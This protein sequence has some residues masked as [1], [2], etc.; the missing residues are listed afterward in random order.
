MGTIGHKNKGGGVPG[1]GPI[2]GGSLGFQMKGTP[3]QMS[4]SQENTFG[5]SGSNPN[6]GVFNGIKV[7]DANKSGSD[8]P[9]NNMDIPLK[10]KKTYKQFVEEQN[11]KTDGGSGGDMKR[12][13]GSGGDRPVVDTSRKAFRA[14][15]SADRKQKRKDMAYDPTNP[16]SS[17]RKVG[18]IL[19]DVAGT[20]VKDYNKTNDLTWASNLLPE[21]TR[22]NEDPTTRIRKTDAGK[23]IQGA[24]RIAKNVGEKVSQTAK[25]LFPSKN[26]RHGKDLDGDGKRSQA[27]LNQG[28]VNKRRQKAENN[29]ND[30]INSRITKDNPKGGSFW[31]N[32]L[33]Q[34]KDRLSDEDGVLPKDKGGSTTTT[35]TTSGYKNQDFNV[36]SSLYTNRKGGKFGE[37]NEEEG[38]I[39]T[40][41]GTSSLKDYSRLVGLGKLGPIKMAM[42]K[43]DEPASVDSKSK[44]DNKKD[45]K[46]DKKK[47]KK[48][49]SEYK[50]QNF[51]VNA[52]T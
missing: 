33:R 19:R 39:Q 32:K 51:D 37:K 41:L 42:V 14:E 38:K 27:E 12:A 31:G 44:K 22:V 1:K 2:Q 25:N 23:V 17:G 16:D 10:K 49:V 8:V 7:A 15:K 40:G 5:P 47:N 26:I 46:K 34:I 48:K 11:S 24:N 52:G 20:R 4:A 21:T 13:L 29:K 50:S 9:M 36:N 45:D 35:N 30:R 3:Y 18:N 28:T 6:P 43:G